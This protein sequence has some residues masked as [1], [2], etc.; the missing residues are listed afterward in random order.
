MPLDLG[1]N[2]GK[3]DVMKPSKDPDSAFLVFSSFFAGVAEV[4]AEDPALL[5]GAACTSLSSAG[6]SG[7]LRLT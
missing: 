3:P 7:S 5:A 4:V 1:L 2:L 6:A